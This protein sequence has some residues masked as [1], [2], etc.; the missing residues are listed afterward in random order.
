MQDDQN[1]LMHEAKNLLNAYS[2]EEFGSDCDFADLAK[3]GIGYTTLGDE[4]LSFQAYANLIDHYIELQI[5]GDCVERVN[6]DSLET[7]VEN[8]LKG[9]SFDDLIHL[10]YCFVEEPEKENQDNK[11]EEKKDPVARLD[12]LATDGSVGESVQYFSEE[13]FLK[14]VMEELHYGVPLVIV[15]YRDHEGKTIPRTFIKDL[16]TL[17]KGFITEPAPGVKVRQ[18]REERDEE[19]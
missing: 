15:L 17:P 12:F 4:E 14:A 10:A 16:D 2:R 9:L 11:P 5:N 6:Y 1:E 8:G 13:E 3:I 19:R 18:S 7:F